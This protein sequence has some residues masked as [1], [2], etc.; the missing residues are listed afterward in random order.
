MRQTGICPKCGSDRI[1][2][3]ARV[4]DRGWED[5]VRDLEVAV[6]DR[7]DGALKGERRGTLTA[8]ICTACGYTELYCSELL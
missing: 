5:R 6:Y 1:A 2:P 3:N 8:W 7:P 4:L